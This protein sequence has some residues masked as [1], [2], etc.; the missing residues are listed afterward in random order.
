MAVELVRQIGNSDSI[1]EEAVSDL[2]NTLEWTDKIYTIL[3]KAS[4]S[5]SISYQE[6]LE[7]AKAVANPN[8]TVQASKIIE[9]VEE[10]WES[11][12]QIFKKAGVV[13]DFLSVSVTVITLVN[14]QYEV[15]TKLLDVTLEG[16]SFYNGLKRLQKRLG[17]DYVVDEFMKKFGEDEVWELLAKGIASTGAKKW[18]LCLRAVQVWG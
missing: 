15:V 16:S 1:A 10:E 8:L 13:G 5:R 9:K 7:V 11:I 12:D 4:A 17:G 14:L 3:S 18:S 6:K 2:N